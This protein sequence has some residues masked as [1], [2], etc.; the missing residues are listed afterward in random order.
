MLSVLCN[1]TY[2][3]LFAAQ[4]IALI[5]TGLA[6]VALGLLAFEL[7]G[8]EA[9]SVLG[10]ALAIKMIAYVGVAPV[11]KD[12]LADLCSH[13]GPHGRRLEFRRCLQVFLAAAHNSPYGRPASEQAASTG[14]MPTLKRKV[15]F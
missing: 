5:G 2:R 12:P 3:H 8:G 15:R 14:N 13:N 4:V 10:M 1:R 9:G 7:A 6:T 11:A